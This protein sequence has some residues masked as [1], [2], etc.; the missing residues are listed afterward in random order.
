M[1]L[2]NCMSG[3]RYLASHM[4]GSIESEV[5]GLRKCTKVM[6]ESTQLNSIYFLKRETELSGVGC[7]IGWGKA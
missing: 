7:Y 2:G 6:Y 3:M 1:E 5:W 4:G